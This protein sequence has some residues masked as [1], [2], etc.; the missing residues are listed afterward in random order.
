MLILL[1]EALPSPL[2]QQLQAFSAQR[3]E[4]TQ[5]RILS[6][7]LSLFLLQ[8]GVKDRAVTEV[9][10]QAMFGDLYAAANDEAPGGLS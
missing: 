3:P 2:T 1:S 5:E 6:S 9:Y 10:L 8:N 7:A 4:W